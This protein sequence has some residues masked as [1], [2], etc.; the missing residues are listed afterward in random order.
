MKGSNENA[1]VYNENSSGRAKSAFAS[2]M[3]LAILAP[4]L[5][6][7]TSDELV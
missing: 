5:A 1:T 7:A 3:L 4:T 2:A 6:S